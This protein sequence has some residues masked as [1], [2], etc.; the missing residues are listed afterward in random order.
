VELVIYRVSK[1]FPSEELFGLTSQL[2]RAGISI[3]NNIAEGQGRLGR[4]E[5]QQ[6]W[7]MPGVSLGEVETQIIMARNLD[8]LSEAEMNDILEISAEVGRI[9]TG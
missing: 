5:F 7:E 4:K 3:P 2:R 8:Y 6:F 1:K 9:L